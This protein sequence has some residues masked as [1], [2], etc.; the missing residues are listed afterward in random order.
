MES[1][2]FF[3]AQDRLIGWK[4]RDKLLTNITIEF[5]KQNELKDDKGTKIFPS[6]QNVAL[7][8]IELKN[9]R[10]LFYDIAV[11]GIIIFDREDVGLNFIKNIRNRI[12]EKGLKRVYLGE[13]DFYWRRKKIKFGEIVEI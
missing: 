11:D 8:L 9:F 1:Y 5:Y 13:N 6:I 12:K 7:T 10:T 2:L 4:F 3:L